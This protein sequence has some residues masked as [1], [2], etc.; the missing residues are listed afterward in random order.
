MSKQ[1]PLC[2]KVVVVGECTFDILMKVSA[3]PSVDEWT[4]SHSAAIMP[5]GKGLNQAIALSRLGAS[6]VLISRVGNDFMG[7]SIQELCQQ[8]HIG[9]NYLK[10]DKL[11]PTPI[12]VI[13]VDSNGK[14]LVVANPGANMNMSEQD[15]L[16]AEQEFA[17]AD[18]LLMPLTIPVK[19][20]ALALDIANS[21]GVKSIV[22][23]ISVQSIPED[24]MR[25]IG[26]L[27]S[28]KYEAELVSGVKI[29][30]CSDA[31]IAAGKIIHMGVTAAIITL[32]DEGALV[33]NVDGISLVQA[34]P[35][36]VVDTT[37][38]GDAFSAA[39][40]ISIAQGKDVIHAARYG[41]AAGAVTSTRLGTYIA[42]PTE[43]EVLSLLQSF[44]LS[45]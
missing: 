17:G 35:I 4:L 30:T 34:F 26:I 41:C 12:V 21:Y 9:S 10:T 39:L 45:D 15:I 29:R 7:Q 22:S 43:E 13:L 36:Q 44:P 24:M 18:A 3:I 23:P 38:A 1:F 8:E 19:V 5:G 11:Q 31:R 32:G 25:G 6:P 27:V 42:M 28:N 14:N 33:A 37:G 40:T 20:A 2:P 16:S